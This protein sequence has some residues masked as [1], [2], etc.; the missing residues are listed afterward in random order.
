MPNRWSSKK[1]AD[2][3]DRIVE[4]DGHR[5]AACGVPGPT[6]KRSLEIDHVD[7]DKENGAWGNLQLLCKPCNVTKRNKFQAEL[8]ELGREYRRQRHDYRRQRHPNGDFAPEGQQ[9]GIVPPPSDCVRNFSHT[10][11]AQAARSLKLLLGYEQ[12]SSE[13]QANLSYEM[14]WLSWIT[15]KLHELGHMTIKEAKNGGALAVGC[16]PFT[17]SRY[18]DKY[19]SSEG[20]LRKSMDLFQYPVVVL[21][22]RAPVEA[23]VPLEEAPEEPEAVPTCIV[24]GEPLDT[25]PGHKGGDME[26]WP[27]D[28]RVREWPR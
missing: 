21:R 17:A 25:C 14:P 9:R 7:N 4:R 20:P 18:L 24:C 5:C 3:Y 1:R 27:E 2:I 11:T 26:E 19:S 13:L 10:H 6:G 12:G 15:Q 28:L 23:E 22:D 16:S 8:A